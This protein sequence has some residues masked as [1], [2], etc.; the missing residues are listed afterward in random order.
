MSAQSDRDDAAAATRPERVEGAWFL[1]GETRMDDQQHALAGLLRTI[2]IVAAREAS[3][4]GH[5]PD[6]GD[7]TPSGWLW[8]AALALALNPARAAFGVPRGGRSRRTVA[9]LA[10]LGGVVGGLAVCAAAAA[11]DPLLDAV[12]VGDPSFRVAAGIV[13]ALAGAGDLFR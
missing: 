3:R 13:A 5:S 11:G 2:P 12:D 10:G 1:D 4:S 9:R 6:S 8:A 7:D